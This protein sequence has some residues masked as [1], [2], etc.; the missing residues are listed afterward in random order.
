M[1]ISAFSGE[2]LRDRGV[3]QP[4]DIAI[5][6]PNMNAKNATG[7]G[8]PIFNIRGV[9]VTSFTGIANPTVGVYV[10]EIYQ[11]TTIMMSFSSLDLASAEVI[12]GPQGTLFGRN[13]TGGAVSFRSRAP[14][15]E[16]DGFVD[17]AYGNYDRITIEA[18]KGA[19]INDNWSLRGAIKKDNQSEG[20]FRNVT[21]DKTVGQ[22]DT[23]SMRLGALYESDDLSILAS[24]HYGY[25]RSEPWPFDPAGTYDVSTFVAD[26]RYPGGG[27]Y[28]AVSR[29][30]FCNSGLTASFKEIQQDPNCVD[31]SGFRDDDGDPFR[32]T[33][34]VDGRYD[35]EAF[36]GFVKV[37]KDFDVASFVSVTGF[38][39]FDRNQLEDYDGGFNTL[40]EV[41][42]KSE[43]EVLTQ[44]FRLVSDSD[45]NLTWIGGVYFSLDSNDTNDVFNTD[46]R[47]LGDL[48]VNYKN[49][50]TSYAAFGQIEYA[51]TETLSLI[52]G[53]RY[54]YEETSFDGFQDFINSADQT[55]GNEGD[56]F[57]LVPVAPESPMI[58]FTGG[59]IAL[60]DE[61]DN[62][63]ITGKIGLDWRPTDGALLYASV[64]RGAK[65]GGFSG[66]FATI[67]AEFGPFGP[68]EVIAVELGFKTVLL[69]GRLTA[70][71][72]LYDYA[73][74]DMQTLGFNVDTFI[75][76]TDNLPEVELRGAELELNWLVADNF[77][78]YVGIGH[79]DQA[80]VIRSISGFA[81]P[82]EGNRLPNTPKMTATSTG[83][84][85]WQAGNNRMALQLTASW[86]DDANHQIENRSATAEKSYM[87]ADARISLFSADES[88]EFTVWA[89]NL[90]DEGY[91]EEN[92][93]AG[94]AGVS[95]GLPGAPRTYGV[96]LR[97]IFD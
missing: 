3:T 56:V 12:R 29:F 75:F 63:E 22:I 80:E 69:D 68:E 83:Q 46:M 78:W 39:F 82:L 37:E 93:F 5:Y 91:Y 30:G 72:A 76:T 50:T 33:S 51:F 13:T 4:R 35:N 90:T 97:Y 47:F 24:I 79:I 64:S 92:F 89:K 57:G 81:I 85:A 71:G 74:E 16:S 6:T 86:K 25:D 42:Y 65:S 32:T 61:I 38:E 66:F 84:F 88:W 17:V 70:N 67:P 48:P 28:G 14:S 20:F 54:T 62:S 34:Q 43:I 15:Q 96:Q 10:D 59:P 9:G 52:L 26:A 23:L 87:V 18:A 11:P 49:E 73:W 27:Y 53:A 41:F 95:N 1:S 2:Q 40:A 31:R 21:T 8:N 19:A 36:G 60:D 7:A 44:E 77:Q 94:N 45:S 55:G 58:G